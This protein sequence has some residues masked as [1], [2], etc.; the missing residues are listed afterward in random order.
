ML[1][2]LLYENIHFLSAENLIGIDG[3]ATVDG[4]HLTDLG[5]LRMAEVL[6]TEI[7]KIINKGAQE[8]SF[9]E[10]QNLYRAFPVI[11]LDIIDGFQTNPSK[12]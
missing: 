6:K 2:I 3:E 7:D 1:Q 4:V 9:S 11:Q 12:M 8:I 5:F 10:L